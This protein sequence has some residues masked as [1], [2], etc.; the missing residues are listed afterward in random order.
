MIK[1]LLSIIF[2]AL[3]LFGITFLLSENSA[4]DLGSAIIVTWGISTYLIWW[5]VL[6]LINATIRPILKILSLPLFFVF[7]GLVSILINGIILFLLNYILNNVL[8]IPGV[9][10]Y[11]AGEQFWVH[12]WINFIIAVAIFTILN[13]I[14]SLLF[15]KR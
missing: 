3:I 12:W 7:F 2:N 8:Q 4:K 5:T 13:M 1:V 14:Y 10:Y 11:I 9:S 15:N 6:W